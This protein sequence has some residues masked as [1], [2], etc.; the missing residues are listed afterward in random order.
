M[1]ANALQL[2][3]IM[4]CKGTG[5]GGLGE[6]DQMITGLNRMSMEGIRL[7]ILD[8]DGVLYRM[9]E[10]L[11]A[12]AEAVGRLC[13]RGIRVF[14]L[15]NNSTKTRHEYVAKLKS[16]GIHATEEQIMT[17]AYATAQWLHAEGAVG[18]NVYVI[19]EQGLKAELQSVGMQVVDYSEEVPIHY[20]VVGWDRGLSYRKL[21]EA[22]FAI[23][24]GATFI[25][26][27]RDPT[28]P[29]AG[30]RTIP[31]GGS[32]VA[33]VQTSTGISPRTIGKPEPYTLQLILSQAAASPAECLVIG[34]RLDTD[35][36][37][38]KRVGARTA[39]VL[40]GVSTRAQ[41]DMA[42]QELRPDFVWQDLRELP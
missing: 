5:R 14:Y 41:V 2:S 30:G 32:I 23:G 22:H 42:P 31:G 25:A 7:C 12:A 16:L 36:A 17:S 39:L 18:K 20:V 37:A 15:T 13:S 21:K 9:D 24:A 33:A 1:P 11:P 19:G 40:T 29:D 26:T 38:G 35:I 8:M 28:Y 6:V 3:P 4:W 34:D 10:P 27:N